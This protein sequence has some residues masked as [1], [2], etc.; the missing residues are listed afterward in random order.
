MSRL[1]F[2]TTGMVCSGC[3]TT[4]VSVLEKMDGVS[5]VTADHESGATAVERDSSVDDEA[6]FATVRDA[7][8]GVSACGNPKCKCANCECDPCVCN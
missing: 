3:S 6:I 2:K 1:E 7:G 4:V 8:F 5:G